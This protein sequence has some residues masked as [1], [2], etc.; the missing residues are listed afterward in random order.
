MIFGGVPFLSIKKHKPIFSATIAPSM[1]K[2]QVVIAARASSIAE[3]VFLLNRREENDGGDPNQN[4]DGDQG[5]FDRRGRRLVR[6]E[7]PQCS[8]HDD[9][10]GDP[11]KIF[12]KRNAAIWIISI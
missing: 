8:D 12:L 9:S 10:V 11:D 3:P 1:P 6:K 5:V 2:S 4:A 7:S